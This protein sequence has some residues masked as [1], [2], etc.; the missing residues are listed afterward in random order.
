MKSYSH[1][2]SNQ[3]GP[4]KLWS[5]KALQLHRLAAVLLTY[6]PWFYTVLPPE[7]NTISSPSKITSFK[8]LQTMTI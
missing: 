1:L 6:V 8:V 4:E 5:K 3:Q 2:Q 7:K